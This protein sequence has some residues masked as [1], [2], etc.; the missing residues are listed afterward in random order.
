M[1]G[2]VN[3]T[4]HDDQAPNMVGKRQSRPEQAAARAAAILI[5]DDPKLVGS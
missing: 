2:I 3:G 5:T 4:I 1:K